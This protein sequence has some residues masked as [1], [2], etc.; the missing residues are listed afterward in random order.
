MVV[1]LTGGIGSGKSFVASLFKK[2]NTIVYYSADE[3]AK[4]LMNTNNE[5]KFGVCELFGN[6]AY[7]DGLLNRKYISSIV[8]KDPIKLKELNKIVHPKVKAH[9]E[10]F[11]IQHSSKSI[12]LYENAILF[13]IGS[14]VKCDKIIYVS[15]SQKERIRRVIKRD[16][17]TEL[18]VLNRIKNQWP[19]SKKEIQSHYIIHNNLDSDTE[20]Q[21]DVI[22]N[23]LTKDLS[24]IE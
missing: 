23:I 22:Y 4:K 15:A 1:G 9:F 17:V 13:E 14:D 19:S 24:L 18:E 16:G 10:S 8:F 20:H 3:E 6:Q 21:V 7:L 5:I 11:V 12:I 2:Y